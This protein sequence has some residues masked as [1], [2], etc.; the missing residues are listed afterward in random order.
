M[1][2]RPFDFLC[3]GQSWRVFLLTQNSSSS[4][5]YPHC[6]LYD[7]YSFSSFV[8]PVKEVTM[9]ISASFQSLLA[10]LRM[11]VSVS[12]AYAALIQ[13]V[14]CLQTADGSLQKSVLTRWLQE[15]QTFLLWIRATAFLTAD[16]LENV[17]LI[18]AVSYIEQHVGSYVNACT[19]LPSCPYQIFLMLTLA[20]FLSGSALVWHP[21]WIH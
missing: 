10:A 1:P 21:Y 3:S 11:T 14:I 5:T 15:D 20:R 6:N 16:A 2:S 8:I 9:A 7:D 13:R 12:L 19:F 17:V 4:W 18:R